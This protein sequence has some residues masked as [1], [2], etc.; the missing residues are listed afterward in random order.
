M[1]KPDVVPLEGEKRETGKRT[2]LQLREEMRVPAVLYGPSI[3]KNIHLH[4]GELELEKL[5]AKSQT[6]LQELT[7]DGETY[8]TLLKRVE[9]DPITDRP[10]HADFYVLEEKY[11]VS[12]QV[13]IR[14]RGNAVGVVD[15][16]GRVFQPLRIVRIKALPS[17]IP[18]Q[19]EV[20]ISELEIGDSIH[21]S[22]LDME[23]ITL[24][25]DPSRTIVT[26]S[27]PKSDEI[28]TT[29]AVSDEDEELEEVAEGEEGVE[30]EAEGEE[31]AAEEGEEESRE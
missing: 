2:S 16:G 21:V 9:F 31:G 22:E 28:F 29:T 7:V 13:P 10:I 25:D 26:I 1:T 14:L 19:F 3:E 23:G 12:L 18:S 5:L 30:G 11:P 24:L 20:D 17:R 8:Q 6:K 15:G 4:V 27:P